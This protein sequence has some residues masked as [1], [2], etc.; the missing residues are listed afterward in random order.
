MDGY[1][2]RAAIFLDRASLRAEDGARVLLAL[3]RLARSARWPPRH[4][5]RA[6]VDG[7]IVQVAALLAAAR[8]TEGRARA[9]TLVRSDA[10]DAAAEL[11]EIAECLHRA[12]RVVDAFAIEGI[13][14][15][16]VEALVGAGAAD[17]W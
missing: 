16:I 12:G 15:R 2:G 7:R 17:G 14:A 3:A 13:E 9:M 11:A 6:A 10:L 4:A 5:R 1:P 8:P